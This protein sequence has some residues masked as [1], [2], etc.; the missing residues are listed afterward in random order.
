MSHRYCDAHAGPASRSQVSSHLGPTLRP[1][2][3]LF[4]R[5]AFSKQ[6][7]PDF[8]RGFL[9]IKG[10]SCLLRSS[11]IG[12]RHPIGFGGST[13]AGTCSMYQDVSSSMTTHM[14]H[15]TIISNSKI[16]NPREG[17]MPLA[18]MP[19]APMQSMITPRALHLMSSTIM[20]EKRLNASMVF[21]LR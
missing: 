20:I 16:G 11:S 12:G 13:Y 1:L 15:V 4:E 9:H 8:R 18:L 14:P 2:F 21:S 5:F 19:H 10:P 6:K 7:S 3:C 17:T